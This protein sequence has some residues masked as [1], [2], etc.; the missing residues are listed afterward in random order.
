MPQA[1]SAGTSPKKPAAKSAAAKPAAAAASKPAPA[2]A[3]AVK[4]AAAKTAAAK[5]A[6]KRAAAKPAAAAAK[7]A[8]AKPAA[9]KASTP[10]AAARKAG[11]AKAT[12]AKATSAAKP[13]AGRAASTAK[14]AAAKA[15]PHVTIH[16][17]IDEKQFE[18][19]AERVRKLNERIIEV[20]REAGESTLTSYEKALKAI[21]T[22]ISQGPAKDELDWIAHLAASQAKFVRDMTDTLAKTARERLK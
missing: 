8:A 17:N 18:A 21:A 22:G 6:A 12:A 2:K 20:G 14:A 4:P 1:R 11:A 7:A 5:P 3:S 19:I 16:V 10:R 9:S 15:K 13:A